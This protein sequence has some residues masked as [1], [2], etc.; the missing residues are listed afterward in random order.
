LNVPGAALKVSEGLLGTSTALL[1]IPIRM[2]KDIRHGPY[3]RAVWTKTHV[4]ESSPTPRSYSVET[5]IEADVRD[6]TSNAI[7][8]ALVRGLLI[9]GAEGI[10]FP[11]PL[12]SLVATCGFAS[13]PIVPCAMIAGLVVAVAV[14]LAT[15]VE[16]RLTRRYEHPFSLAVSLVGGV[17]LGI[18]MALTLVVASA[19]AV[20]L[21]GAVSTSSVHGGFT[22]LSAFSDEW[23][24]HTRDALTTYATAALPFAL[25]GFARLRF[26][27]FWTLT[28]FVGFGTLAAMILMEPNT[29]FPFSIWSELSPLLLSYETIGSTLVIGFGLPVLWGLSNL[30]Q[31]ALGLRNMSGASSNPSLS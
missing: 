31:N 21:A 14:A 3:E 23:G 30:I 17:A 16:L 26:V 2:C 10:L 20:Y 11:I 9:G 6:P 25:F 27:G 19:Q 22:A 18:A 13:A 15:S 5:M 7:K 4:A 1:T 28:L 12:T 29:Y 24:K 8:L